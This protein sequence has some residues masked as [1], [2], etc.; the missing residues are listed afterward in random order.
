LSFDVV[1]GAYSF[2]GR[3][4]A[5]RL[6]AQDR[7]IRTLTNHPQR[8]GAEDIR[9]EVAPLQFADRDALVESMR[10]ADVLYNTYWVRFRHGRARFGEAVANTRVLMGAARDAGVRRVV[11]ISVSNPSEDSPLDYY[12]GKARAERAVRE[13]G[14][15]WA[16]VRPTLIFGQGDILINNIAW[17]LRRFPI[18]GIPG[19]GDYRLQPVA[20]EDVA[21]IATWAAE[22]VDNLTVDAAGPDIIYYSEMVES[23]AIAVR[24]HPRFIYMS[25]RNAMRAV[26]LLGRMLNDIV[27]NE[28][29]LEGLMAEL[30]V[31]S[32]RPRGTRRLDNWLLTHADS[33]GQTYAS[34]LARHWR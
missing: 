32:E 30:L 6:M 11:H 12:A 34:E 3:F 27:L 17:M 10:G 28:P 31:S 15:S 29:E 5:Q 8:A 23:I 9:A 1:T 20:G 4:I 19:R 18:F 14:V 7:N 2:T 13:S 25:P 21:E 33:I 24:R 26:R 22:Q 16:I